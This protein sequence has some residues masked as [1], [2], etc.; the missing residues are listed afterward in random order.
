MRNRKRGLL[1][2]LVALGLTACRETGTETSAKRPAETESLAEVAAYSKLSKPITMR[3]GFKIPDSRLEAGDSNDNNPITNYLEGITNIKVIHYW[4]AKG[5]DP[6]FQRV[7]MAI[8]S[9]DLPDALVVNQEQ[10]QRLIDNEMIEDLTAI[11]EEYG[12]K[13]IKEMYSSTEGDAER[14][15]SRNGKLYGLPNVALKADSAI[16]LWVR[17]DWLS[18]LGLRPPETLDEIEAIAK[19]FVERDPDGNGKRDTVG[20]GGYRN[21]VYGQKPNV[22]GFDSIFH[23]F[24]AYPGNWIRNKEGEIVYGSTTAEAKQALG[25]LAD[26]YKRGLIDPDFPL[27]QE[28]QEPILTSRTGMFFGPWWMPYYPLSE[29]VRRGTT[30]EWRAYA[31]PLNASGQFEVHLASATDRYLVVR[32]GYEHPEAVVKLVNAFTRLERRQDPNTA[33]VRK[34]EDFSAQTGIQLRTYYPFDLL[35]DDAGA[36]EKNYAELQQAL[37]GKA[38]PEL[39]TPDSRLIYNQWIREEEQPKK[40]ME[41]WKAANAYKYGVGVLARTPSIQSKSVFYGVTDTMRTKWKS[42]QRMENETF[43]KIVVGD[44]P[45]SEFDTFVSEWK[46]HGGEQITEE[47]KR[48]VGRP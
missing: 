9:N 3:I 19:A 45:M 17:E 5:D 20:I 36:I 27:Y 25:R 40:D 43:L 15:A 1:L 42:L 41:G 11:F 13:L 33:E 8:D 2:L 12:S 32:K 7:D 16:L 14:D 24:G 21:I 6:Y 38:D 34:L 35:I 39:L 22:N 28:T 18:K 46:R 47:V 48:A 23:A 29:A 4:E 30:A 10:L 26:W 37:H 31:V 44:S